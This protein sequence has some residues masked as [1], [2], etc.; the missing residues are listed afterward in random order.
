MAIQL[1]TSPQKFGFGFYFLISGYCVLFCFTNEAQTSIWWDHGRMVEQLLILLH[2]GNNALNLLIQS[3]TTRYVLFCPSGEV[4]AIRDRIKPYASH[5]KIPN[6]STFWM[7][8]DVLTSHKWQC[9]LPYRSS[10]TFWC[11]PMGHFKHW[12]SYCK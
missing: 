11:L 7:S 1:L 12:G 4:W 6:H 9:I 3:F 10:Q 2:Y 5:C 8:K